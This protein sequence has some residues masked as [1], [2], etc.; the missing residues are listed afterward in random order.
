MNTDS[1]KAHRS[2]STGST[3]HHRA[4]SL[5][6]LRAELDEIIHAVAHDLQEPLQLVVRYARLL[7]ER[8]AHEFGA[9]SRLMLDYLVGSAERMQTLLDAVLHYTR[10]EAGGDDSLQAVDLGAAAA[11][12]IENLRNAI[13]SAGA[14]ITTSPLPTLLAD[15][16]QMV[17]LFQ[18]LIGNAI[19]FSG[20]RQ[21]RVSLVA[22]EREEDWLFSVQDNGIGIDPRHADRIFVMFQRLHTEEEYP[23][24]GVGLA[25]CRKIVRRH[26]GEIWVRS[27]PSQGAIFYF[28]LRKS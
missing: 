13:E 11:A 5:A 20:T 28:T 3:I 10:P 19:K 23:G 8:H 18:N 24:T 4:R 14:H 9:N 6:P 12:A 1:T 27:Q 2:S 7:S 15:E 26:G 17:Q 25:I 21:L 16:Q 22:K